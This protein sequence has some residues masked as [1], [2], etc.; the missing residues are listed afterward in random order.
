MEVCSLKPR[1]LAGQPTSQ[2][3]GLLLACR[4]DHGGALGAS[5]PK[6]GM[7]ALIPG[8]LSNLRTS[9]LERDGFLI[10]FPIL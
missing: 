8:E 10:Y 2:W 7:Y 5:A 3:S 4:L 6:L 9:S 1:G